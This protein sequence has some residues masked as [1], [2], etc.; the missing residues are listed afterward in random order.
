MI[1]SDLIGAIAI[2]MTELMEKGEV[3]G[4]FPLYVKDKKGDV[5]EH[6][7]L[8]ATFKYKKSFPGSAD[9]GDA[10]EVDFGDLQAKKWKKEGHKDYTK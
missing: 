3:G 7:H 8:N 1:G 2:P 5:S 10:K 4:N 9:E 6:G